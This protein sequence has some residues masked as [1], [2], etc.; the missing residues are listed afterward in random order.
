[1]GFDG[2]E[3]AAVGEIPKPNR[4][5]VGGADEH[6]AV[7][8]DGERA[9]PGGVAFQRSSFCHVR[10][11]EQLDG[12]VTAPGDQELGIGGKGH[13]ADPIV[14]H[15]LKSTVIVDEVSP[16]FTGI[17]LGLLP[18]SVMQDFFLSAG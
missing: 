2:S 8:C 13:R 11:V 4:R 16:G 15:L 6:L 9:H 14:H 1:M 10:H 3:A 5:V 7:R 17:F 12:L 18:V